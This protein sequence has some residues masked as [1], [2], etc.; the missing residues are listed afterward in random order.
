MAAFGVS[1]V[2]VTVCG[3][4]AATPARVVLLPLLTSAAPV[5]LLMPPPY[6]QPTV[7]LSHR[8]S[9]NMTSSAVN[10]DPSC[11]VTFGW[12]WKVQ[13]RPSAEVDQS[14]ASAG[15]TGPYPPVV[16]SMLYVT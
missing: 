7:G 12:R 6:T 15:I 11:Q 13:V 16:L 1:V 2:I 5:M 14:L 10:G 9:V 4:G 8:V 3:S